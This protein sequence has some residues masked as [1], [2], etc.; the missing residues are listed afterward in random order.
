MV[1]HALVTSCLDY[2]NALYVGLP[3]KSARKLQLAQRSSARLQTGASYRE[4]TTPLLQQLNWLPV[5]FRIQFK[6]LVMTFK[7]LDGSGPGYLA[8]CVSLYEPAWTLR[9]SGEAFLSIPYPSQAWL[10]GTRNQAFSVA[11]PRSWNALL[12]REA[13][14]A[15]SLLYFQWQAKIFL[16]RQAFKGEDF[17]AQVRRCCDFCF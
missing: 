16:F 10:V 2:C 7:A 3:L 11:A 1:V 15:L 5:C 13:R 9:S 6:V 14:M 8:D 4:R 17:K 12:P